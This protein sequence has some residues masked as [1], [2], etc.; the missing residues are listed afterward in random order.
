M[1][2]SRRLLSQGAAAGPYPQLEPAAKSDIELSGNLWRKR[3]LP[4]GQVN[5]KGRTLQFTREYLAGLAQAFRDRAYSQV[6]LQLATSDNAHTNDPERFAG[7][8]LDL[9][10]A[11]D[12]L[13][14]TIRATDRGNRVLQENPRIGVSARI[15]EDFERSD[16]AFCPQALQH[17]L[18]TLDPRV[19]NLGPWS[20]ID[21]SGT[22]AEIV[23]DLSGSQFTDGED[24]WLT[25]TPHR[26]SARPW[27]R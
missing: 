7:E 22:Q 23:I 6:P 18:V 27:P 25:R 13:W 3:L 8:V 10:A 15:V 21:A 2:R 1:L 12:G 9:E 14:A 19:P 20:S 24:D 16:G 5:Y 17:A 4:V 11:D 26:P